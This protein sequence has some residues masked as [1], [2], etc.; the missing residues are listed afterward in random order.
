[1]KSSAYNFAKLVFPAFPQPIQEL[2]ENDHG[3]EITGFVSTSAFLPRFDVL[4]FPPCVTHTLRKHLRLHIG[5]LAKLSSE[6]E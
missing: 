4:F 3:F 5:L 6:L 2:S 1:M